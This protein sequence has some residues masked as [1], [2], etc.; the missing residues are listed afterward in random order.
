MSS[1]FALTWETSVEHT[2]DTI[3]R[4]QMRN[5]RRRA[6]CWLLNRFVAAAPHAWL[7]SVSNMWVHTAE[8]TT[9]LVLACLYAL[10]CVAASAALCGSSHPKTPMIKLFCSVL[11][12]GSLLR[13]LY[14]GYGVASCHGGVQ[15]VVVWSCVSLTACARGYRVPDRVY[16]GNYTPGVNPRVFSSTSWLMFLQ[17]VIFSAAN[18]AFFVVYVLIVQ[19]WS[20]VRCHRAFVLSTISVSVA[21]LYG[22]RAQAYASTQGDPSRKP[23]LFFVGFYAAYAC[24]QLI[25]LVFFF[26]VPYDTVLAMHSISMCVVA[27]S[28]CVGYV[29]SWYVCVPV[30][31][32]RPPA[33]SSHALVL[34]WQAKTECSH[35]LPRSVWFPA[36]FAARVGAANAQAVPCCVLR[37]RVLGTQDL[38]AA[39]PSVDPA[40]KGW[41]FPGALVV[42]RHLLLILLRGVVYFLSH[43]SHPAAAC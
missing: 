40:C 23:M 35:A 33:R 43:S 37:H 30:R 12:I 1:V 38:Y 32:G 17:F 29:A 19:F 2:V 13:A 5:K 3:Q 42:D 21:H 18:V 20:S 27:I 15:H 8:L 41:P 39:L 7:T 28:I 11:I 14:L 9:N 10:L 36:A 16:G 31:C 25:L 4:S 24:V 6:F 22:A 26:I 34:L